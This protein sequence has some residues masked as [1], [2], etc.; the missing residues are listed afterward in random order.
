MGEAK[1]RGT[2]EQ[3][4]AVAQPKNQKTPRVERTSPVYTGSTMSRAAIASMLAF[5][6]SNTKE[7]GK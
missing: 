4:K 6:L 5:A 7:A 2:Y 1:R 3:R